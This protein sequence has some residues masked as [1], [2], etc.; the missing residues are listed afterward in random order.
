MPLKKEGFASEQIVGFNP[1]IFLP[2]AYMLLHGLPEPAPP[3]H[4]GLTDD[5]VKKIHKRYLESLGREVN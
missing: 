1:L 4:P 2:A 5:E 3:M